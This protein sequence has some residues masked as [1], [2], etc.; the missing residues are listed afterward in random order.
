MTRNLILLN[1]S[2]SF[3]YDNNGTVSFF[4]FFFFTAALRPHLW[5]LDIPRLGVKSELWLQANTT[6][7]AVQDPSLI[8]DLHHSSQQHQ[9]PD[10]LGE[11]KHRTCFFMDTSQICFR[12]TTTGIPCVYFFKENP[13]A[14][15]KR[16]WFQ[17]WC[18]EENTGWAWNIQ[19][20]FQ[21]GRKC[22]KRNGRTGLMDPLVAKTGRISAAK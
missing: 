4:F 10:P 7:T 14:P 21:K 12:C 11:A 17:S 13:L 20:C 22:V 15:W 2:V 19:G 1:C 3:G 18:R 8:C 5:H 6:A 9:I 16:G